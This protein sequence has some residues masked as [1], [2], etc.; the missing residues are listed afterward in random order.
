MKRKMMSVVMMLVLAAGMAGCGGSSEKEPNL[1]N[2]GKK[3][4]DKVVKE[5]E[6]QEE[7]GLDY[8][9]IMGQAHLKRAAEIAAAGMHN[10][11][12]IG[13]AGTGKSMT[14]RRIPT[15]M[16]PLT[17]EEKREISKV[18]SICGLLPE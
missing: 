12:I 10:L 16:P 17:L 6:K 15:I 13:P 8:K 5:E 9:D 7:G 18:Y 2:A 4:E 3:T 1:D 11:L 14:A